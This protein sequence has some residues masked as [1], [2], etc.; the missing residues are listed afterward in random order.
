MF[1]YRKRLLAVA[2]VAVTAAAAVI[3]GLTAADAASPALSGTEHFQLMVVSAKATSGPVIATGL[4]TAGG[5]DHQG[6]TTDVFTFPNGTIKVRHSPGRGKQSFNP[7]SCLLT[8]ALHG[9]YTIVHGTGRYAGITGHGIYHLNILA[10][11]ARNA[12]GKCSSKAPPVVFE[13]IIKG[14]GPVKLK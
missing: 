12:R 5:V 4:F 10:I 7:R 14:S 13:Q 9:T 1:S 2:S 6:Q 11:G 8:I 3:S